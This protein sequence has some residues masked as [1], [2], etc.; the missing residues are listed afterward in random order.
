M[1]GILFTALGTDDVGVLVAQVDV[2]D[3]PLQGHLVEIY[4]N[5]YHLEKVIKNFTMYVLYK[6]L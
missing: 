1:T 5:K 4:N 3:V 2:I 6:S